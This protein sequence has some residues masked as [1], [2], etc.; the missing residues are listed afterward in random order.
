MQKVECPYHG[1]N[2]YFGQFDTQDQAVMAN[3]VVRAM[4]EPTKNSCITAV[5]FESNL[6]LAKEAAWMAASGSSAGAIAP[7]F[8]AAAKQTREAPVVETST[9]YS[10]KVED[11]LVHRRELLEFVQKCRIAAEE[12][13]HDMAITG[14][15]NDTNLP[16]TCD[17]GETLPEED[18]EQNV[19]GSAIRKKKAPRGVNVPPGVYATTSGRWVSLDEIHHHLIF[20]ITF[21]FPLL[22]MFLVN[23]ESRMWLQ[24]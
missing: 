13:V 20:Y 8:A 1:K 14:I 4:L 11:K 6:K 22:L 16:W 9:T 12:G 24:G 17:C 23:A 21:L 10:Q 18:S 7:S 5:E 15:S 19:E 3:E 2:R